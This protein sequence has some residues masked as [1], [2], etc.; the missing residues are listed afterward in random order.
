[1]Q[2]K[3]RVEQITTG[4]MFFPSFSRLIR[5]VPGAAKQNPANLQ[6][7]TTN[8]HDLAHAG[9]FQ[10]RNLK[11]AQKNGNPLHVKLSFR[12]PAVLVIQMS[13]IASGSFCVIMGKQQELDQITV[14]YLVHISGVLI[15]VLNAFIPIKSSPPAS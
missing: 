9:M 8:L 3:E 13:M 7:A 14:V 12:L 1:M 6:T 15:E 11:E 10:L 4:K 5:S 2:K